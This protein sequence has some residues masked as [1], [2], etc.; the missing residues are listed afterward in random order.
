MYQISI[1]RVYAVSWPSQQIKK[2]TFRELLL[3]WIC[4]SKDFKFWYNTSIQGVSEWRIHETR[5]A[6]SKISLLKLKEQTNI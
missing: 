1:N 6:P 4:F 2:L 5:N 3:S